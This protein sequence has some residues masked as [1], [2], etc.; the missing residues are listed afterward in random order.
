MEG[1][2]VMGVHKE[3]KLHTAWWL[4]KYEAVGGWKLWMVIGR[5]DGKVIIWMETGE[6]YD[7]GSL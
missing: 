6:A 2:E 4:M 7:R 3:Q 1:A 5:I